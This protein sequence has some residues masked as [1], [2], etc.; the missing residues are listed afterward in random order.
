MQELRGCKSPA[1]ST[2]PEGSEPE[3]ATHALGT[4][5]AKS[6][7][8]GD[9]DPGD[10]D[11]GRVGRRQGPGERG[12]G[13]GPA[14]RARKPTPATSSSPYSTTPPTR[15]ASH[16]DATS[17]RAH[18]L[19]A[20][21]SC[22]L[23]SSCYSPFVHFL[24]SLPF[25]LSILSFNCLQVS[26]NT[27]RRHRR[28]R[29]AEPSSPSRCSLCYCSGHLLPFAKQVT[30]ARFYAPSTTSTIPLN[31]LDP[32]IPPQQPWHRPPRGISSAPSMRF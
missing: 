25:R 32:T 14:P 30:S 13:G 31:A 18:P 22:P 7:A 16:R 1:P 12:P 10:D 28:H 8:A 15:V 9:A 27:S 17:T 4:L 2:R 5:R 6:T 24:S 3:V 21:D 19:P 26:S 23:N 11:A 20:P 29:Q